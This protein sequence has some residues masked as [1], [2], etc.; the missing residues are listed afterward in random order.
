MIT[1]LSHTSH[2][3]NLEMLVVSSPSKQLSKNRDI[4]AW[5]TIILRS[6]TRLLV[7]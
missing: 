2:V 3:Y 4:I 6:K 7:N 5:S 1:L